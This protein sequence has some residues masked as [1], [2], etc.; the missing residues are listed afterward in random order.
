MNNPNPNNKQRKRQPRKQ[1]AKWQAV[2]EII[3][4][5]VKEEVKKDLW[6]ERKKDRQNAP[7]R[8]KTAV[9]SSASRTSDIDKFFLSKIFPGQVDCK[10]VANGHTLDLPV[11]HAH[12]T[13]TSSY[14]GS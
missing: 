4:E 8:P 2:K 1:A 12:G 7:P 3:K 14:D 9:R 11:K 5:E 6:R 10:Y 13:W